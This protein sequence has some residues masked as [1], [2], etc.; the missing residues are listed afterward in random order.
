MALTKA[1]RAAAGPYFRAV[2]QFPVIRQS[3]LSAFDACGLSA[4]FEML[5]R[6]GWS[7]HPQARGTI[8]HRTAA[9]CLRT[10]SKQGERRIPPD[11]ALDHLHEA[12]RQA[13]ADKECP[14]CR[15]TKLKRGINKN[16]MRTCA[17]SE[18]GNM[19]ATEIMNLPMAEVRDL[20]MA[21]IKWAHDNEWDIENLMD[22]EDR[23]TI[24]AVYAYKGGTVTR[25]VTGQLDAV[26]SDGGRDDHAIVLD[27]KDT[28]GMPAPREISEEGYF[29]QRMYGW[30]LMRT[31]K[32]LN[33]VTLREF[34]PRYS[35][36]REV[37]MWRDELE[38]VE[39]EFTALV[40]RFDRS[41]HQGV[42]SP[43]PGKHCHWCMRPHLCP[44]GAEDRAEGRIR[45][46]AEAAAVAKQYVVADSVRGQTRGALEAWANAN[47]SIPIK[48]A[49]GARV[50]GYRETERT[51]R[52]TKA[53][54]AQAIAEAGGADRVN[55][56]E[57]FVTRKGTKFEEHVP[58]R[59]VETDTDVAL[60]AALE[61][62]LAQALADHGGAA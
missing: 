55:L 22:V 34:Y 57:L 7:T 10:M 5:A 48:D 24:P 14:K 44:I 59:V 41:I 13:D 27:W 8:F 52:P 4:R 50:L 19:F 12:L 29:Q 18:C 40:E 17:N 31:Y 38:D 1:E 51:S 20:R 2:E 45:T 42:Y 61:G 43:T 60:Q 49:K 35:E 33:R 30:L 58:D 28:W 47:G 16:G 53:A 21:T 36:P 9:A 6:R 62:S 3:T 15:G 37:T 54:L 25:R 39:H 23:L 11:V 56:D 26:F 46:H 32:N